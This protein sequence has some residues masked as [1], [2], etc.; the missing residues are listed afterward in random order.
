VGQLILASKLDT[1]FLSGGD[2]Q[3]INTLSK[4]DAAE[5]TNNMRSFCK[6]L[7]Q[8]PFPTA[9]LLQ[10]GAFGGGAEVALATDERWIEQNNSFSSQLLGLHFW[11]SKWSVPGG[12]GG[13]LRLG[14]LC[15]HLTP[16]QIGVLFARASSLDVQKLIAWN[17]V[18][19]VAFQREGASS[20]GSALA[21]GAAKSHEYSV[22]VKS[23]TEL[24][25]PFAE[26]FLACGAELRQKL[27]LRPHTNELKTAAQK[28]D[29]DLFEDHWL[30]PQHK[31][32]IKSF[33]EK[34]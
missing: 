19:P 2:L 6:A 33:L 8:Y 25:R 5:L 21:G 32:K 34:K 20:D 22:F 26:S 4:A 16:R 29:E 12:W 28:Y 3:E 11:Q 9:A 13:M 30:S 7:S 27:L 1:V 15:P 23:L 24:G 17:L 18:N 31:S 14:E 10:G